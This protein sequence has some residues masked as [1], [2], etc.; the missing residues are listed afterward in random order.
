MIRRR[1]K[2]GLFYF[3][4]AVVLGLV[5]A[6]GAFQG[7]PAHAQTAASPGVTISETSLQIEEGKSYT[8]SVVLDTE[9]A[10]YVGVSI[11]GR[12]GLTSNRARLFFTVQNWNVPQTVTI[13]A[14]HD[15]DGIDEAEVTLT[16][17]VS[18]PDDGDYDGLSAAGVT[19]TVTDDDYAELIIDEDSLAME[20]GDSNYI[21]V[22]LGTMPAGTV[23]VT[24][25]GAIGTDVTLDKSSLTFTPQNWYRSQRVTFTVEQ[26]DDLADDPQVIITLT[27]SSLD[28]GDY[29]GLEPTILAI[30]TSDDDRPGVTVTPDSLT[31]DEGGGARTYTA[32]LKTQPTA[33]V[34]VRAYTTDDII[35]FERFLTFTT[36]N[37]NIPQEVQ[38]DFA[39]V[40][41]NTQDSFT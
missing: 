18:S 12:R 20:E 14:D 28:D 13:T 25:G 29:D 6:A 9:P 21:E 24:I 32:V 5:I 11:G 27:A 10:S 22:W 17:T 1:S 15:D 38:V 30:N 19:V 3:A 7:S 37:W 31:N 40:D 41:N 2:F 16:H 33:E 35:S 34:T 8:Y 4:V 39:P 23:T 36:E 26:D